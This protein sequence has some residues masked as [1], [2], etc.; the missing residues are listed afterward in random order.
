MIHIFAVRILLYIKC[1]AE[2]KDF[3]AVIEL[4]SVRNRI[5]ESLFC[6]SLIMKNK[7]KR[8]LQQ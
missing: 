5:A 1:F 4:I 3:D 6:T 7:K 8:L 2:S